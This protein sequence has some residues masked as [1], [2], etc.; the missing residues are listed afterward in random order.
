M[1]PTSN[2][3]STRET[4][5]VFL[6]LGEM[7]KGAAVD[8]TGDKGQTIPEKDVR[9]DLLHKLVYCSALCS[10]GSLNPALIRPFRETLN[11]LI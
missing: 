3:K 7:G 4:G 6:V 8:S 5:F 10:M 9:R 1:Q 11:T 2:R